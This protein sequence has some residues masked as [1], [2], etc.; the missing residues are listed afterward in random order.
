MATDTLRSIIGSNRGISVAVSPYTYVR[1]VVMDSSLLSRNDFEKL[2][3]M[4]LAEIIQ[5]LEESSYRK[6]IDEL[7]V[8]ES[9]VQLV[10]HAV[11]R[12]FRRSIEKLIRISDEQLRL[13]IE[14]YLWR[15]DITNIKTIIRAKRSGESLDR[16]QNILVPGTMAKDELLNLYKA[17]SVEEIIGGLDIPFIQNPLALYKQSGFGA[18]ENSLT[19]AY[20]EATLSIARRMRGHGAA[21]KDFLLLEVDTT[22]IMTIL[23][24]KA[25]GAPQE[26]LK[27][28]L[29]SRDEESASSKTFLHV[30][31]ADERMLE[32]LI[33]SANV[34]DALAVLSKSRYSEVLENSVQEYNK[35]RSLLGIERRLRRYVLRRAT[36]L[37]HQ[38]PLSVDVVVGYLFA[39]TNEIRNIFL[40]IKGKQ[41]GI[42]VEVLEAEIVAR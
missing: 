28:F 17:A 14:V 26:K 8:Q 35:N 41:L 34:A 9:G 13:L 11:Q 15:N 27:E 32:R 37:T 2:L 25:E 3:K 22:N 24:L 7:A 36:L 33:A 18:F 20:Y 19:K 16:V 6:E 4:D 39:K 5:F 29:I 21:F 1:T 10:E 12:N 23:K 40:L 42:S 38:N 30:R 31:T